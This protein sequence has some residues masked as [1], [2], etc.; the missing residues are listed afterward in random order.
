MSSKFAA[1]GPNAYI[2]TSI[3]CKAASAACSATASAESQF[4]GSWDSREWV[5]LCKQRPDSS[6]A[7]VQGSGPGGCLWSC[8]VQAARPIAFELG[9]RTD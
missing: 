9:C 8:L 4:W 3:R 5:D 6:W 2:A 1:A 7:G